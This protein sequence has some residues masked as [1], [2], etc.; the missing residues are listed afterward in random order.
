MM[1]MC[2]MGELKFNSETI[3][4]FTKT[5]RANVPGISPE[6]VTF[7]K[8]D[9]TP[10]DETVQLKI[11]CSTRL[12]ESESIS[13]FG[14]LPINLKEFYGFD[15]FVRN[16]VLEI[17]LYKERKE[18]IQWLRFGYGFKTKYPKEEQLWI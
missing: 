4:E 1:Q 9:T 16:G 8:L 15:Y 10:Y 6:D 18:N 5:I 11:T 14:V 2:S 7:E 17:V 12:S 13:Y 3:T